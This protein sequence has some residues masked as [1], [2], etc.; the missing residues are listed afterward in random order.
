MRQRPGSSTRSPYS[1]NVTMESSSSTTAAAASRDLNPVTA[2]TVAQA[3]HKTK[4]TVNSIGEPPL[5]QDPETG[6]MKVKGEETDSWIGAATIPMVS[7]VALTG[8]VSGAFS[9]YWV[10]GILFDVASAFLVVSSAAVVVQKRELRKLGGF[11]GL[12]NQL[13][14]MVNAIHTENR[15]LRN[16]V[17]QLEK[18]QK[19]YV[20]CYT[21][22]E[23]LFVC[24]FV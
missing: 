1:I 17:T 12:H 13:R 19:R 14:G 11:R 2:L 10:V 23:I 24:V 15:R 5:E 16:T 22:V 20:I 9:F 6:E 8:L 21:M 4:E 18:H 7:L 3:L